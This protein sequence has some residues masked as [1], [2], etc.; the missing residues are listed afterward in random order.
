[1]LQYLLPRNLLNAAN[2]DAQTGAAAGYGSAIRET[3]DRASRHLRRAAWLSLPISL[4]GLLP[5]I[6]ILQV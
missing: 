4:L 1:M 3:F 2:Q 6:F 5:S